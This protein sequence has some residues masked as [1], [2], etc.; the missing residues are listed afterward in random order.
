[1]EW[2]LCV[3]RDVEDASRDFRAKCLFLVIFDDDGIR[4]MRVN[5]ESEMNQFFWHAPD[6]FINF[7]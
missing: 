7:W 5:D 2:I 6:D 1:M 3:K 4:Y